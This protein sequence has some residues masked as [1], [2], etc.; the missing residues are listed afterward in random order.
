MRDHQFQMIAP[1]SFTRWRDRHQIHFTFGHWIQKELNVSQS[2]NSSIREVILQ[3]PDPYSRRIQRVL[4]GLV[5]PLPKRGD[6]NRFMDGVFVADDEEP[7]EEM[8]LCI[9]PV[10]VPSS[11]KMTYNETK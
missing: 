9:R 10:A 11:G 1:R 5:I 4:D 3:Y 6:T 7:Q 2:D 8:Y